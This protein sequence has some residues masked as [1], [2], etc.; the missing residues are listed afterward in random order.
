MK[1]IEQ[2]LLSCLAAY[3]TGQDSAQI[4]PNL[5]TTSWPALYQLSTEQRLVP[6]VFEM[7]W[8]N[9]E[10][11]KGNQPLLLKWR[12]ESLRQ[13]LAQAMRTQRIVELL[14]EFKKQDIPYILVKGLLCRCLYEKPDLRTS[15][16][17]DLLILR[18]D[19]ER[20]YRLLR[21]SGLFAVAEDS[22]NTTSHWLD[23]A[24][25]LHIDLHTQLFSG[26]PD[27]PEFNQL[28]EEQLREKQFV[29]TDVGKIQSV[30]PTNY[31]L[32]L[33]YHALQH[34]KYRGIGV[35]IISDIVTY[36]ERYR[37]TIDFD[38][39]QNDL[40]KISGCCF[41]HQLFFIGRVWLSFTIPDNWT[42]SGEIDTEA[43]LA[44]C[45]E[46]GIHGYAAVGRQSSAHIMAQYSQGSTQRHPLLRTLFP[47][48]KWLAAKYPIVDR[49]PVLMPVCW[50]CRWKNYVLRLYRSKGNGKSPI[51]SVIVWKR[52]MK[53]MRK[54]KI[55]GE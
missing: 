40:A 30:S 16:D 12:Q 25:G 34:F 41:L 32:F 37:D 44:D 24:T 47:S 19:Q 38:L 18:E 21:E 42:Y 35:R 10:F 17:E 52:R 13:A 43:L 50:V 49:H 31:F 26:I 39:L 11:C 8:K 27:A 48:R 20:C 23:P 22:D 51:K 29:S 7:L 45:L 33:V 54:Y 1:P 6:V 55:I 9:S 14:Q 15:R 28:F 36:A 4:I 3:R 46:G 2:Q 53:L 5:D